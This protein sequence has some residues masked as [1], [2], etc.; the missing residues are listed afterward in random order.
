MH[1]K[2][3]LIDGETV[4]TGSYNFSKNAETSNDENIL[5]LKNR[6]IAGAFLREFRRCW[7]GIKGYP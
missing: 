2:V 5:I 3:I 7:T 6:E 4:I 1:H